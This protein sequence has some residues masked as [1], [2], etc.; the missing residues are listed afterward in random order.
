MYLSDSVPKMYVPGMDRVSSS[1]RR[2]AFC[3]SAGYC[4]DNMGNCW[5][6]KRGA[7][8]TKPSFLRGLDGVMIPSWLW[9]ALAAGAGVFLGRRYR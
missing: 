2:N 3:T 4:C 1:I 8:G 5:Q 6:E 7:H 9:L